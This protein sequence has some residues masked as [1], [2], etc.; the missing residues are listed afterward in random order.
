MHTPVLKL[1]LI[2]DSF[3]DRHEMEVD[4]YTAKTIIIIIMIEMRVFTIYL[5]RLVFCPV[6]VK[7]SCFEHIICCSV[8]HGSTCNK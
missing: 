3:P 2:T 5:I 6:N 7:Y 8:L 4:Y 1:V